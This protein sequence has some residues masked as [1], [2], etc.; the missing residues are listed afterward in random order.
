[1]THMQ[2]FNVGFVIDASQL[3][4]DMTVYLED[5]SLNRVHLNG[6]MHGEIFKMSSPT[7][8]PSET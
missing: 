7:S 6:K 1:M 3:Y 2:A 5:R 8:Q 4:D